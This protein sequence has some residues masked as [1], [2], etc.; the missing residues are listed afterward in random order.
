MAVLIHPPGSLENSRRKMQHVR[1]CSLRSRR[2]FQTTGRLPSCSGIQSP[3]CTA[4]RSIRDRSADESR[5]C[6][7]STR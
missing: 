6:V 7:K 4:L 2:T 1:P 3:H 5:A